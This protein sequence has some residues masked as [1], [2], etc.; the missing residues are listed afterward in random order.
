MIPIIQ[1]ILGLI[2][3]YFVWNFLSVQRA[4]S[5]LPP[6]PAPLPLI[7][8]L[9]TIRF[10]VHHET[11]LKMARRHG[12]MYTLWLGQTPV[13]V[14]NGFQAVKD[15]LISHSDDFVERPIT[16]FLR[17]VIGGPQGIIFANGH[18][19]KQQRRFSL[20]TLRN[21]GLGK[22]TLEEWIQ[23]QAQLLVQ[24]FAREKG[25]PMDPSVS[26][27]SSINNVIAAV[28][29]GHCFSSED[30]SFQQL[31]KGSQA[32]AEF[33]GT[34]WPRLYD[35]FPTLMKHLSPVFMRSLLA[36]THM[37]DLRRL[38]KDEIKSH[39]NSW[40]PEKPQDFI[41]SYLSQMWKTKD[42][43]TSTFKENNMIQ[44]I[45]DLFIAGSDTTTISLLWAILYMMAH[46]EIQERVQEELDAIIGSSH[47]IRYED[48]MIL[49]Y[50]NAV[51]HEV[52]R[53]SS[54]SAIGVIRKCTKDT[55]VQGFPVS[56]GTLIFPNLFSVLYDPDHWE[57][58]QE[59]NPS[60]FLDK[61]GNFLNKEAF[62]PF[63][64]GHRVCLGE[65]LAK[66]SL[67]IMFSNLLRAFT[68]RLPEG[69][70]EINEKP[71]VGVILQPEPYKMCAVPR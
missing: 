47:E 54:I 26:I 2:T 51:L 56:K 24:T 7:G 58:P 16:P 3:F 65:Q 48:R 5:K 8:N 67:F 53:Y 35:A 45:T 9:W 64:A 70:K 36:L 62:L 25:R 31:F 46:P 40:V 28:L 4:R 60:H 57:T 1:I 11:L 55:T 61:D 18:T 29:F 59:F 10:Q 6:G 42:N 50:T 14:L 13:I 44:V 20:M 19:W 41:D 23:G 52:L 22:K 33:E 66:T 38:V 30:E 49:P 37:Q 17:D 32:M 27:L 15:A 21:L 69:V 34:I 39:Q 68:F 12:N 43:P 63:S 71:I